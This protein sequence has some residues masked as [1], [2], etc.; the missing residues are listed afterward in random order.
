MVEDVH[1]DFNI[2]VNSFLGDIGAVNSVL[3][4]TLFNKYC[5]SLYGSQNCILFH[6]DM[7]NLYVA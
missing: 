3:K 2:K 1:R 5:V 7:D 4:N 6:G